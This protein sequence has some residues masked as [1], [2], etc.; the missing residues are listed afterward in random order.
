MLKAG[1]IPVFIS[2]QRKP[3]ESETWFKGPPIKENA[4]DEYVSG[5]G[6]APVNRRDP[7]KE[8]PIE[9]NGSVCVKAGRD[10]VILN[11]DTWERDSVNPSVLNIYRGSVKVAEFLVWEAVWLE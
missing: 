8:S 1:T 9:F 3:P 11:A 5:V 4:V 2:Q 6:N 7:I 10:T